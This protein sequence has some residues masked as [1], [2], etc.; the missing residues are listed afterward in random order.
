M[1]AWIGRLG[2]LIEFKCPSA[3][4]STAEDSHVYFRSMGGD[5]TVDR[6]G[7]GTRPR[8][9]EV[10]V[11]A[12]R[13][14][15]V[16][17]LENLASGAWGPGPF[18][19]IPPAAP[20][21]NMLGKRSSLA[22]GDPGTG[23]VVDQGGAPVLTTEGYAGARYGATTATPGMTT[24]G[25]APV[26]PG[27]PV[28]G[29]AWAQAMT[30]AT[31]SLQLL[32]YTAGHAHLG[33]SALATTTSATGEYLTVTSPAPADAAYVRLRGGGTVV[34]HPQVTWTEDAR[35]WSQ[36]A[37]ST[38]VVVS[39]LSEAVRRATGRPGEETISD[40]RFTVTELRA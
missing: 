29:K 38:Q 15:H 4:E 35:T 32:F 16:A 20:A 9:W 3:V 26:I 24:L 14:D 23:Y 31:G 33:S 7:D 11:D 39:P 21:K 2:A 6:L 25:D 13:P 10:S 27:M 36:S 34:T 30:G 37:A 19:F 5:V 22:L 1:S 8:V 40:H 18:V 28:T 12:A 17:A